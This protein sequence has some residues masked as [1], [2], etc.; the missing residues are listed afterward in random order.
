MNL[1]NVSARR[2]TPNVMGIY[3]GM[4][5]V[6]NNFLWG[7]VMELIDILDFG[8][9]LNGNVLMP[10]ILNFVLDAAA[11]CSCKAV[12]DVTGYFGCDICTAE[13]DFC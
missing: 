4:K 6:T 10:K 12:K 13:G 11:R 3:Y 5:N 9:V 2:L 7:F 8:M 1:R